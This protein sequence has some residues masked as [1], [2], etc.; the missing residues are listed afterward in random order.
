ML[1]SLL[2]EFRLYVIFKGRIPSHLFVNDN[3]FLYR[4]I[5][6]H[7][8]LVMAFALAWCFC[9][10]LSL[11]FL[12]DLETSSGNLISEHFFMLLQEFSISLIFLFCPSFLSF[13]PSAWFCLEVWFKVI[14]NLT[15]IFSFV[16]FS[17]SL[18]HHII[19]LFIVL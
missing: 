8:L 9:L 15:K 6:P 17:Y 18:I 3:N 10:D 14:I 16:G 2:F 4:L 11:N 13:S 5:F 12:K 1:R 7:H 19:Y